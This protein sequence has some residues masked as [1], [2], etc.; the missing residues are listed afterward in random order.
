MNDYRAM[1]GATSTDERV[2]ILQRIHRSMAP[3]HPPDFHGIECI[4]VLLSVVASADNE[5]VCAL[6][7]LPLARFAIGGVRGLFHLTKSDPLG[8]IMRAIR[9]HTSGKCLAYGS[10][11]LSRLLT[12]YTTPELTMQVCWALLRVSSLTTQ[13]RVRPDYSRYEGPGRRGRCPLWHAV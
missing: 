8:I 11:L 1:E 3:G 2:R 6:A 4:E 13:P 9:V 10:F 12:P 7:M 5:V